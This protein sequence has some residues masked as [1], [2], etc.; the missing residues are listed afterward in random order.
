MRVRRIYYSIPNTDS[1]TN[2]IFLVDRASGKMPQ[3]VREALIEVFQAQGDLPRKE[4][5][6]ELLDMEME[7]RYK[8]ETW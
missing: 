8:Q 3:A 6:K 5:E 7:G 2:H 1:N 4:A